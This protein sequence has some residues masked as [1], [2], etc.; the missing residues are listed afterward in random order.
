MSTHDM[1]AILNSLPAHMRAKYNI[2]VRGYTVK[3]HYRRISA[4]TAAPKRPRRRA[5]K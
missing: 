5:K 3:P 4:S 1:R 2:K